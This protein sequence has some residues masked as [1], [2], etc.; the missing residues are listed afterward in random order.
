[1]D[2]S[3]FDCW[4]RSIAERSSLSRRRIGSAALLAMFGLIDIADA[5]KRKK[6]KKKPK[7]T[8]PCTGSCAGKTCGSDGCGDNNVCGSCRGGQIC[9]GGDCVAGQANCPAGADHCQSFP[10][11]CGT[12]SNCACY[13]TTE[14]ETRCVA[15]T[16][17]CGICTS[18][19]DCIAQGYEPGTVCIEINP[20]Q[21]S[22]CGNCP[23][24]PNTACAR[25]CPARWL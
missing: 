5:K 16:S 13:P 3:Q 9:A 11:F 18:S 1:M 19:A 6:K 21:G 2:V 14:G 15:G 24:G 12:T 8:A 10:T 4:A 23:T 20:G 22:N 7:T 17:G 25:P